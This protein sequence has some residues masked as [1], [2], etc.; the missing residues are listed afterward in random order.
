MPITRFLS[1]KT[2]EPEEI[3]ALDQA[4]GLALHAL[5]L[6]NRDDPAAQLVARR[7]LDIAASGIRDPREISR[8]AVL[9]HRD[10]LG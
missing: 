10:C 3:E 1:C 7:V 8:I 4:L 5:H 9:T 6:E 2:L